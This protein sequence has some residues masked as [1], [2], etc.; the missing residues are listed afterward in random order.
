MLKTH[1]PA[2]GEKLAVETR[3]EIKEHLIKSVAS[4]NRFNNY[5]V[6]KANNLCTS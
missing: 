2:T 4:F 6:V 1:I 3:P 5:I